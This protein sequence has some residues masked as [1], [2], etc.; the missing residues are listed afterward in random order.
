MA[1]PPAQPTSSGYPLDALPVAAAWVDAGGTV[2]ETN[3][4][5]RQRI[6]E[7]EGRL[8]DWIHP[9][10]RE[11]VA[12]TLGDPTEAG[13]RPAVTCRLATAGG[14]RSH[15]LAVRADGGIGGLGL[16]AGWLLCVDD[17]GGGGLPVRFAQG[18]AEELSGELDASRLLRRA[19]ERLVAE[20]P[21]AGAAVP[22]LDRDGHG[23]VV[24]AAAGSAGS[25][26]GRHVAVEGA[27]CQRLAAGEGVALVPAEVVA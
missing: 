9:E 7:T 23:A 19:A 27:V 6:G 11:A 4:P 21:V 18:V 10:D 3:G 16:G 26:A 5:W 15:R 17:V 24:V 25:L 13:L 1:E 8:A 20:L 22:I 2:R 14:W 12:A